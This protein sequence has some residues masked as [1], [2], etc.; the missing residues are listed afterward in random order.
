MR[1]VALEQTM[2]H[3]GR[4]KAMARVLKVYEATGVAEPWSA[5]CDFLP[6]PLEAAEAILPAD[7]AEVPRLF[8]ARAGNGR[9][10]G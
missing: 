8:P 6:R 1:W 9:E 10:A 7:R 2:P 4:L 3:V 5:G